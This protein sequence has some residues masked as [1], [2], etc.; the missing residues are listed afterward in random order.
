MDVIMDPLGAHS[1]PAPIGYS[2]EDDPYA[3]PIDRPSSLLLES[4]LKMTPPS[5][6]S[7]ASV[8]LEAPAS[9]REEVVIQITEIALGKH[10]TYSIKGQDRSGVFEIDRRYSDFFALREYFLHRWPGVFIPPVPPKKILVRP[11]TG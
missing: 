9:F 10:V 8:S 2:A 4:G 1:R 6:A 7:F 3:T 5:L 11:Y